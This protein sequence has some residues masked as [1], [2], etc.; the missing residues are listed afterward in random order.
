VSGC[1]FHCTTEP[2]TKPAPPTVML[3][4]P[5]PAVAAAGASPPTEEATE[6]VPVVE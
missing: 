4:E 3:K 2:L 1:P 5:E 6:K